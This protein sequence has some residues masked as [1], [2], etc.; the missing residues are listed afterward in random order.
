M[1]YFK[2]M[3]VSVIALIAIFLNPGSARAETNQASV[4]P[5]VEGPI[6]S[7]NSSLSVV[8]SPSL[9]ERTI[10]GED[11]PAYLRLKGMRTTGLILTASGGATL[12]AG[13]IT[14]AFVVGGSDC[15][16]EDDSHASMGCGWDK[17]GQTVTGLS[18]MAG[19]LLFFIPGAVLLVVAHERRIRLRKSDSS[20]GRFKASLP[21]LHG[22]SLMASPSQRKISGL[23][24]SFTF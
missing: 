15:S 23:A 1:Q 10:A 9:S 3:I 21:K 17:L 22:V 11:D 14:L 5:E 4:Q 8:D 18:L 24:F 6:S 13:L 16:S 2:L 7:H 19:S 20:R 12:I